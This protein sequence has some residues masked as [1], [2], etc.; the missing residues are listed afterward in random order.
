MPS[1]SRPL[2]VVL[3]GPSGAGKDAVLARMKALGR[4]LHFT[5]T[6][7]TRAKRPLEVDGIDYYFK[8]RQ[9]FEAMMAGDELLEWAKVYDQYYGVPRAQVDEALAQGID[10]IVRTDIQGAASIRRAMP[11]A[12]LIFITA[13]SYEELIKRLNQRQTESPAQLKLRLGKAYAE[14]KEIAAFDYIVINRGGE[15][16]ET[17]RQIDAIMAAEKCRVKRCLS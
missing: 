6:T 17:I 5:V 8:T 12:V 1:A 15:L 16:D 7:T 13:P 3:S 10:V 2:L 9:E 4:P 14:M 11:D